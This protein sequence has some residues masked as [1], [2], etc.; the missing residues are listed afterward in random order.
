MKKLISVAFACSLALPALAQISPTGNYFLAGDWQGWSA[1]ANQMT[2]LGP[3]I[4]Q[5][6]LTGLT[7]GSRH[8]FEITEGDWN[9]KYPGS[10]NGWFY[11]DASGNLTF[12]YDVNTYAD[13][14]SPSVG[15][16]GVTMDPGTWTAVGDWQGWN[17]ANAATAMT[18]EGGGIYELA[19]TIGTPGSYQYKAV[20]T[21]SWDAI[22]T[23]SR[24]VNAN[25]LGFTT[26]DPNQTVDFFVNAMNGTIEANVLPVPEPSALA[27]FGAGVAGLLWLRRRP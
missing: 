22:G 9:W 12:T 21:G 17:N 1:S 14:W 11:A 7:P 4:Y 5:E 26:T 10:G 2:L 25:T 6:T 3:G 15:R 20:D 8:E 19:Y 18:A 16:I 13:G 23:D 24:G 27:L